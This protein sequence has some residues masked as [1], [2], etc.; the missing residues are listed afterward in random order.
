M[1]I[2]RIN[3]SHAWRVRERTLSP[4]R[5]LL[6]V[7][8]YWTSGRRAS[9][10]PADVDSLTAR[11]RRRRCRSIVWNDPQR[12]SATPGLRLAARTALRCIL[13]ASGAWKIL[14]PGNYIK[15]KRTSPSFPKLQ[16]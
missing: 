7:V 16:G 3:R 9:P 1:R 2:P 6:K 12:K 4:G 10:L 5:N 13:R 8:Y 15:A 14:N 11:R